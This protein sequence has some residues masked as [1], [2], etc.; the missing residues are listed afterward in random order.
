MSHPFPLVSVAEMRALEAAAVEAGTPE[1]ELQERAGR[2]VADVVAASI[3]DEAADALVVALA[4]PG[5]NGRDAA[6]A[7]RY[8]RARGHPVAVWLVGRPALSEA[9]CETLAEANVAVF[10]LGDD[11]GSTPR[12]LAEM[13]ARARVAL[14]GLLGVGARGPMRPDLAVA[15]DTLN[16]VRGGRP[17]LLVVAVDLPSGLDA[18]DGSVPGVAVRAD[19]TVTFG[20][21]KAGLLRFPGAELVG[22]LEPRPIGLQPTVVDGLP[23]RV[24]DP[25]GVRPLVPRRPLDGHKYRFGRTLVV[26]G[27]DLYLGAPVLATMA[28]A[29]SGCGL[30]AVATTAAVK[31]VLAARAPEATYPMAP[32]DLE[33]DPEGEAD[34]L[35]EHL[36]EYQ[37]LVVGPGIGRSEPTERFLRRLLTANAESQRPAPAAIDADALT[38][39]ARWERWWE[40]VGS[41][42]VLTPHAGEMTRL[43]G[44]A[45]EGEP[46]WERARRCAADW[47]QVVVLKG[48]FTVVAPPDGPTWVYP[49]ANPGLATAGTGDVLAGL[50]GGLVAQG[51]VPADAARLAVV[52]HAVAGRRILDGRRWRTLLA[53]DLVDEIPAAL[54]A[55]A[56]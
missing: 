15:A 19:L 13:L 54:E 30:V 21:V 56:R 39:L 45:D 6:V 22:R 12:L 24:L 55:V 4:G 44:E 5:N 3:E 53:S 38:L 49:H 18:D 10:R 20:A 27:S 2:A 52:V 8:L 35:A 9:E 26:A 32:L 28:A 50:C 37:A 36:A 7:G 25:A 51:T 48:P 31:P 43:G 16:D 23:V 33:R 29:R 1:H 34:R 11:D 42:H 46:P 14:D 40:R 17:E 41:G 47:G